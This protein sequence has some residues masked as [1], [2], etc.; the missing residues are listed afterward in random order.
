MAKKNRDEFSDKV[1]T[2]AAQRTGYRC[3][4]CS[5]S[6]I[7]PSH[8]SS[9]ATSSIGE[10]AH[11]CAAARG[12]KRYDPSMT[13]EERASIENCIWMCKTHARLIDT[14]ET[15]YTVDYLKEMKRKAEK[16]AEEQISE[17]GIYR[18]SYNEGGD[19][20]SSLHKY[21]R[22]MIEEGSFDLLRNMLESYTSTISTVYDEFVLR[23]K[24][25]YALH[26][27]H[28]LLPEYVDKYIT[29]PIH[30]GADEILAF[31]IP[32][33]HKE[34][35]GNLLP[36]LADKEL[37]TI[38]Q[39]LLKGRLEKS[40]I[41]RIKD[42]P[43][44]FE[45]SKAKETLINSYILQKIVEQ[46]IF[47]IRHIDGT[48]I[49]CKSSDKYF[50][51]LYAAFKLGRKI[52]CDGADII[53]DPAN[54]DYW[55]L[56]QNAKNISQLD[57]HY[58]E[59][60][61][62]PMLQFSFED[63]SNFVSLISEIPIHVAGLP[64]IE[65]YKWLYKLRYDYSSIDIDELLEFSNECN[66]YSLISR[67]LWMLPERIRYEYVKEHLYLCRKSSCFLK[68]IDHY[69]A[70]HNI[71]TLDLSH[72]ADEMGN[73]FL[74]HC[75][76]YKRA[77]ETTDK[78]T[79][80]SWLLEHQSQIMAE[81]LEIYIDILADANMWDNLVELSSLCMFNEAKFLV[82][83][84]LIH[85]GNNAYIS[86][87]LQ[88]YHKLESINW[89][90]Q[91]L[92]FNI[93]VASQN[94]G[95]TETA[96]KYLKK[97]YDLY[98]DQTALYHFLRLRIDT[99][100]VIDDEYLSAA[101]CIITKDFQSIVAASYEKLKQ[102]KEV[103]KHVL[104]VLLLDDSASCFG[105]LCSPYDND[106]VCDIE[107]VQENTVC[108]LSSSSSTINVAIHDDSVIQN[109]NPNHFANCFHYSVGDVEI[110]SLLYSK[111]NDTV[112]FESN[113]YTVSKIISSSEFF[114]AYA[115]QRLITE[116]K[117]VETFS[118]QDPTSFFEQIKT[119]LLTSQQRADAIVSDYNSAQIRYPISVLASLLGRERI[120][121]CEFL[122]YVNV[123]KTKNNT[124]IHQ[125]SDDL[126]YILSFDAVINLAM[127]SAFSMIPNNIN[128]LCPYQ[129]KK[130][131]LGDIAEI[132]EDINHKNAYGSLYMVDNRAVFS[133]RTSAFK[134]S[135]HAFLSSIKSFVSALPE[136]EAYD[137]ESDDGE[138][139]PIF[140]EQKMGAEAGTLALL[141]NTPNA[142]LVTDDQFLYSLA[143]MIGRETV[144]LCGFLTSIC[145]DSRQL[146]SISKKAKE[147]NFENYIPLFLFDKI[148]DTLLLIPEQEELEKANDDLVK[149]LISDNN[150]A[151]ASDY[152]RNLILQLY[153]DCVVQVGGPL[154]ADCPLTK[155]AIHHYAMLNPDFVRRATED[156]AKN[157]TISFED[158]I[159]A[160]EEESQ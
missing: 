13:P 112:T 125:T 107:Y 54:S 11:I 130:Q 29:L 144:G 16:Y 115:M 75:L 137:Y 148:I 154:S 5:I 118:A 55:T 77:T 56:I 157:I 119:R 49:Q 131:I 41:G 67:Y 71:C 46:K 146:L 87:G 53:N 135:R 83:N 60:L 38:C 97:E 48:D 156:Y 17:L 139:A 6:T 51:L 15:K 110:S 132:F 98:K 152:H 134:R 57:G 140:A 84:R 136:T 155:I 47:Y 69:E 123:E 153:R 116:G 35:I 151:D 113:E 150:D 12:G 26:C 99:N 20:V 58:Q 14:D 76:C 74:F 127:M 94:A 91:G 124:N 93:A 64:K 159:E 133:E 61:W 30:T 59:T 86:K 141:Q 70:K 45:V 68:M 96:K 44:A 1:K 4:Y 117:N 80:V 31:A 18:N 40:L 104:R 19:D 126:A 138:L 102:H 143:N 128:I 50:N 10:A 149:W 25:I 78:Q 34:L 129:V 147:I 65:K 2:K 24:I 111:C 33:E 32:F 43:P 37:Q 42:Q 122:A 63:S 105:A 39:L 62:E 36:F 121:I 142:V 73:D 3:S 82:A 81:D 23:F 101:K 160:S 8:E 72:Y 158:V 100:D 114:S 88:I 22:Q 120:E 28:S 89:I 90:Q 145:N 106:T 52:V 27:N 92:F 9:D 7:G 103:K 66:E 95:K 109:F 79:I 85:C 108:V 21:F